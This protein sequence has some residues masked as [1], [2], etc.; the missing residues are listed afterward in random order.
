MGDKDQTWAEVQSNVARMAAALKSLGLKEGDR[1]AILALNSDRY[2]EYLLATWWA[3]GCVVPMNVRWSAA[4]NAYSLRDSGA[5]ILFVDAIFAPMFEAIKAEAPSIKHV[6]FLGDSAPPRDMLNYSKLLAQHEPA[7]D[8]NRSGEDLAGLYYTGGTTGF[9]KGV[10]LSHRALWYNAMAAAGMCSL[11]A[12]HTYLH[13]A[14]MFHLADGALSAG[15]TLAGASHVYIPAFDPVA[16]QNAMAQYGV[17]HAVLVPTMLAM[18]LQHPE[19]DPAKFSSLRTIIYGASPMPEGVL[20]KAMEMLPNVSFVQA[21]GQTEL[22]P[23]AT[24]LPASCHE[25]DGEHAHRL[26]SAGRTIPGAEIRLL[27]DQRADVVPGE[28]GEIAVRSLGAMTGYWNMPDQTAE[29]LVD[30]WVHTGDGGYRD[31]DGF[32]YIVDRMKDMIVTGGENV[33]SAEVESALSTHPAVAEAAVIG[34]PAQQWGEAVHAVIVLKEGASTSEA[35]LIEH[36]RAAIAN[37]KLPRSVEFRSEPLPLSGAGKVLK[38]ELREPYWKDTDRQ[39][40]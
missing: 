11:E 22:G 1:T 20:R 13:A 17:T 40:N 25:L 37:Y 36:C 28:V 16:T 33:F 14:P 24:I 9:P 23:L 8:T 31:D 39:V 30:G 10:M 4:E 26:R 2:T 21:Y 19:F 27:D 34:I 15:V 6:I 3:G 38:R 35:D 5:E 7:P 12:G 29:T 32:L 18:V